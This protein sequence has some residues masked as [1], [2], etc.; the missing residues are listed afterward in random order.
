[1]KTIKQIFITLSLMVSMQAYGQTLVNGIY[2]NFS[3]TTAEVTS[4]PT[5]YSGD[6]VIP[7]TVIYDGTTYNVTSIGKYAFQ[8]CDELTSIRI[9]ESVTSI[10]HGAFRR[11]INLTS[12]STYEVGNLTIEKSAFEGCY[13][14][15]SIWFPSSGVT[16]I[17]DSTFTDCYNLSNFSIPESVTH[18][19]DWAFSNCSALTWISIPENTTYIG[20]Y[21]FWGCNELTSITLPQKI[22]NIGSYAFQHCNKLSSVINLNPNPIIIDESVFD[23]VDKLVCSLYVLANSKNA[24][25]SA[26]GW[27]DFMIEEARGSINDNL[28]WILTNGILSIYGTGDMPSFWPQPAPWYRY[29]AAITSVVIEDGITSIGNYAFQYCYNLVS[30]SIPTTIKYIGTQAFESCGLTSVTI[31]DGVTS[32]YAVFE[33][34]YNLT[35]VTIPSSVTEI[36]STFQFCVS[37]TSI[38]IPN[39]VKDIGNYS[40]YGC[41]N[42]SSIII[43]NSVKSIGRS[44]FGSCYSLKSVTIPKSVT[45]ITGEAFANCYGL[46]SIINLN[47]TPV[48]ISSTVF[49][50]IDKSACTLYV[51][52]GSKS[53]YLSADEWKDFNIIEMPDVS[54]SGID[55][56]PLDNSALV[57]WQP[58]ESAEGYRLLIYADE[59]R[60]DLIYT[61]EFDAAGELIDVITHRA[62]SIMRI[63]N[64]SFSYEIKNLL[65]GKD[66][67]YTLEVLGTN[68][69]V[70]TSISDKFTTTGEPSN[71]VETLRATSLPEIVG[72]YNL[73][74]QKLKQEP[75]KG[76][77]IILYDNGKTEKVMK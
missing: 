4:N 43:P 76:I 13:S 64:S 39:G 69:V 44:A 56:L 61:L 55:V 74:G 5:K 16:T 62:R 2:Y 19:G 40:F 35:S 54:E 46:R 12:V 33:R 36:W 37:L 34:C 18:I 24:Y 21:T 26:N 32:I 48:E 22:T 51:P 29:R 3:G 47:P 25:Q 7:N 75:T 30:A 68:N 73:I 8:F 72:Y 31:P 42:L 71:I 63:A 1:M 6:V 23:G 67:Y 15:S 66:Y 14:L 49:Y 57:V 58:N 20:N 65:S 77:Y 11:C 10:G 50:A 17:K 41:N 28:T 70:L 9:P 38:T 60:T 53:A 59:A 45:S 27:K 52:A